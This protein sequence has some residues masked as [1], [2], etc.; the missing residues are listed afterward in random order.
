MNKHLSKFLF[1]YPVTYARGEFIYKFIRE[2]DTFQWLSK[3][4]IIEYQVDYANKMIRHAYNNSEF[5]KNLYQGLENKT[6]IDALSDLQNMPTVSK[7]DLISHA[8]SM[9]AQ[10]S[11]YFSFKKTTGGSTGQAVTV[12][13]NREALAR[14][15][16]ATWI[17]YSWAG[18]G[19]GDT[20]ARFWGIPLSQKNKMIYKLVD[21]V[22][23]RSRLSAFNISESTLQN[24]YAQLNKSRP[25]YL[26]GY[27]SMIVEFA[28]FILANNLPPLPSLKCVVTTSEV[29]NHSSRDVIQT[30]FGVKVFNE[31]GCGEVGSIAHECEHGSMHIMSSNLIVEID[32]DSNSDGGETGELL[33]TD[34]HNYAM[35][36]I[37]Y[38]LGD[39]A[40]LSEKIC[41][42]GR[43]LPV[44]EK[45]H[46][47]AYDIIVDPSGNKHHPESM[48]YIFEDL[49]Q[50]GMQAKQFQV[51]QVSNKKLKINLTTD[52]KELPN[53]EQAV[54]H[55]IKTK[56]HPGFQIEFNYVDR[57]D[58]EKSGKMRVIKSSFN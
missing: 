30:A 42:C 51:I 37:R 26:Y 21:F 1:Y 34:L 39:Y 29:L 48:M 9:Q 47:R 5:Y 57:I 13:K 2:Y 22:A 31:Y 18:I 54:Q 24:Y 35:P 23:N 20:Q 4:K 58:R 49:K 25:T 56:I 45:I 50:Q 53:F 43:S 12:S 14:E 27:V 32:G 6:R 38:R 7:S 33:V 52:A 19:I 3:N 17:A 36:L 41:K 28:Q 8:D 11:A 10:G 15:R 55:L 46:G 44:I 40:T 16:A